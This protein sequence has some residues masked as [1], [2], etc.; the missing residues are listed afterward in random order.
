[1][2][3]KVGPPIA[4]YP[5]PP[6]PDVMILDRG[7]DAPPPFKV[8]PLQESLLPNACPRDFQDLVYKEGTPIG[9]L[10]L[11]LWQS[12]SSG[13][14]A[15][16]VMW[17]HGGAFCAG[18]H[19]APP[20]WVIPGFRGRGYH[21]V[22]VGYRLGPQAKI[23]DALSDCI[24]AQ[25]WCRANLPRVVGSDN[26]DVDAMV[27]GGD[28]AGGHLST[29][30]SCLMDPQPQVEID[31][32]GPVDLTSPDKRARPSV[33]PWQ[34][35]WSHKYSSAE[36]ERYMRE[37]DTKGSEAILHA[38][39][40]WEATHVPPELTAERWG[41]KSL[42][43]E[44]RIE[45]QTQLMEWLGSNGGVILHFCGGDYHD[46]LAR[47]SAFHRVDQ[48][49][50][51]PATAILHGTADFVP[52]KQSRSFAEKLRLKGVPVLES[53]EEGAPHAFDQLYTVSAT[54]LT[55]TDHVT[56]RIQA[57]TDGRSTLSRSWPLQTSTSEA[58][59]PSRGY[60]ALLIWG[61][62]IWVVSVNNICINHV[63]RDVSVRKQHT[64]FGPLHKHPS[65]F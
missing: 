24:D 12:T 2:T 6:V 26:I 65:L 13:S 17:I 23:D 43:Y 59:Q 28:S 32:Y 60:V 11:R 18:S 63:V 27:I 31:V 35:R 62:P 5:D 40:G 50:T 48:R 4:F 57:S 58:E 25:K 51:Y 20:S 47:Y 44:G 34:E 1:M 16:W 29:L 46:T 55:G 38:P 9:S 19:Y 21:V 56:H 3:A 10:E 33:D 49:D 52:I 37:I 22:S 14:R 61:C 41:I 36:N 15:P 53:Y 64:D 7:P 39:F 30:L 8:Y 45:F 42:K 54:M